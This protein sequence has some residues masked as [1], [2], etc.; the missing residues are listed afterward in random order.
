[1]VVISYVEGVP[2]ID[3]TPK[4]IKEKTLDKNECFKQMLKMAEVL[5]YLHSSLF[6]MHRDLHVGNWMMGNDGGPI[7]VDFGT[8]FK[9]GNGGY[10]QEGLFTPNLCA[11][12]Q[13]L[14]QT[15][16]FNAD[17]WELGITF[18]FMSTGKFP[19][20][21]FYNPFSLTLP[22]YYYRL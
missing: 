11:P 7:L 20:F 16:S 4:K 5:D 19:F 3:L 17:V 8:G 9:L 10:T 6:M 22:N 15:Y 1:M 12:E 13:Y 2:I 14:G 18:Y 21:S